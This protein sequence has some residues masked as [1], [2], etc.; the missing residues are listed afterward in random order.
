MRNIKGWVDKS[1]KLPGI[2]ENPMIVYDFQ[3]LGRVDVDLIGEWAGIRNNLET[4][5]SS[6]IFNRHVTYA[7]LWVIAGFELIRMLKKLDK[8]EDID[9]VYQKFRRVRIPLVKFE[10][11]QDKKGIDKY[12]SDFS[13]VMMARSIDKNEFG[14]AVS[15]TTII[16]RDELAQDLY[17]LF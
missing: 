5:K 3:S 17:D 11:V 4:L 14:W 10:K 7:R 1:Y 6:L 9:K 16:T 12:P 2:K 13:R 8:C 15:N